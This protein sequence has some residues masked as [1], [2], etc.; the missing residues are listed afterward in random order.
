MGAASSPIPNPID[1]C[2]ADA[3]TTAPATTQYPT[4]LMPR[5]PLVPCPAG[6][7]PPVLAALRSSLA[8]AF[9]G[10]CRRQH[11]P[12]LQEGMVTFGGVSDNLEVECIRR[13]CRRTDVGGLPAAG[14]E[15]TA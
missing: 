5:L 12:L 7:G 15:A 4:T 2:S 1:A 3:S 10:S 13:R 14:P 11:R 8:L 6:V 9:G